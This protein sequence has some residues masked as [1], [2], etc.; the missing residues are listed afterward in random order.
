MK[1]ARDAH[2]IL[3]ILQHDNEYE[4]AKNDIN[5]INLFI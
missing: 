4:K 5:L 1:W 3:F 2:T